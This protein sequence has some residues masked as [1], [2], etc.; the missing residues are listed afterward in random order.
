VQ[1][2]KIE[3]EDI[4]SVK[5]V[6]DAQV[7]PDGRAIAFVVADNHK[8]GPGD[9]AGS[10]IW[11]A[12]VDEGGSVEREAR[13]FTFGKRNDLFPR[14]SP[15]GATLA[16]LSNREGGE[17]FQIF[18]IPRCGGEAIRLTN[19]DGKMGPAAFAGFT[20]PIAWS[21]DGTEIAFLMQDPPTT[22]ESKEAKDSGG[23]VKV[24]KDRRFCRIWTVDV[25]TGEARA[26]SEAARQVW[27]FDWSVDGKKFAAVVSDDPYEWSWYESKLAVIPK[28]TGKVEVVYVPRPRQIARP[29]WSQD[30]RSIF[31]LSSVWSDRGII[32]GDLFVVPSTG[33]SRRATDLTKGYRGSVSWMERYSRDELVTSNSENATVVL[34]TLAVGGDRRTPA[35]MKKLWAGDV[36]FTPGFVLRFSLSRQAQRVAVGREGLTTPPDAWA[37]TIRSDGVEWTRLSDINS[38]LAGLEFADIQPIEWRSFDGLLVGGFLALPAGYRESPRAKLPMVVLIHG[39]PTLAFRNTFYLH[40]Y[41]QPVH[42]LASK[43][44]AVLM[45]NIRGSTGRGLRFAEA[46]VGE[47]GGGDFKDVMA[48]VDHCLG[49]GMVDKKRL[50][51]TGHSYGGYMTAWAV[52]QTTRFR[53]AVMMSGV[54]DW[55]S[56]HGTSEIPLWDSSH[57]RSDPYLPDSVQSRFSPMAFV[58]NTDLDHGGFGGR[59]VPARPE[60]PVL[61]GSQGTRRGGRTSGLSPRRPRPERTGPHPPRR[62]DY[63]RLVFEPLRA[64]GLLCSSS[65]G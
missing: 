55:L 48:G 58:K 59:F 27:E 34:S 15:D 47:M 24:E 57:Y 3:A 35:K 23:I 10:S 51:I 52:T 36:V 65:S 44:Y 39:G 31:F 25:R 54:S 62:R 19:L 4:L 6:S 26:R 5:L 12:E 20:N 38:S 18:T 29:L 49:L 28:R 14:W 53:A 32:A 2:R 45:P 60:P 8:E 43:G 9:T 41:S 13:R 61:P 64:C 42:L 50:Y 46:N 16:F 17:K 30:G 40:N 22:E 37:G 56:Y 63:A 1:K 33:L 7:S 11:L 21:P